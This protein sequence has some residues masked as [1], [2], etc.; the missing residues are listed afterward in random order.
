VDRVFQDDMIKID[1]IGR[2]QECLDKLDNRCV[3]VVFTIPGRYHSTPSILGVPKNI[4]FQ[5]MKISSI[6]SKNANMYY[7]T[8]KN[9]RRFNDVTYILRI[10]FKI[11]VVNKFAN[12]LFLS[13]VK[14]FVNILSFGIFSSE[15]VKQYQG[16]VYDETYINDMEDTDL[17]IRLSHASRESTTIDFKIGEYVGSSLG[18]GPA[19]RFITVAGYSYFSY[20]VQRGMINL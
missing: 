18:T 17:S 14:H 8:L 19:Q 13:P 11:N 16:E 6:I 10:N 12:F 7:L 9:L 1:K 20:K 15:F 3:D 2:L 5:I 4:F